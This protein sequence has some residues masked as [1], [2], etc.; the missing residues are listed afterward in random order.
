MTTNFDDTTTTLKA[1]FRSVAPDHLKTLLSEEQRAALCP[2]P[3]PEPATTYKAQIA[4]L[5]ESLD[6]EALVGL[7]SEQRKAQ[8]TDLLCTAAL[9]PQPDPVLQPATPPL[10]GLS[11]GDVFNT[12]N[13]AWNMDNHSDAL[14]NGIRE[15][16][17]ERTDLVVVDDVDDFLQEQDEYDLKQALEYSHCIEFFASDESD[18]LREIDMDCIVDYLREEGWVVSEND[19]DALSQASNGNLVEELRRRLDDDSANY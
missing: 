14:I 18:A 19:Y 6:A 13:T 10:V 1:L 8:V 15:F 7:L 11:Q 17:V 3:A 5:V 16:L 12:L 9:A 4:A 2:E